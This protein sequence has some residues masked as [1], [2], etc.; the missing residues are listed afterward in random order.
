MS[1]LTLATGVVVV[2]WLGEMEVEVEVLVVIWVPAGMEEILG[3]TLLYPWVATRA[4]VVVEVEVEVPVAMIPAVLT[5]LVPEV[6][7]EESAYTD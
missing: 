1:E 3:Q 4:S 6:E 2:V 7:V 5:I